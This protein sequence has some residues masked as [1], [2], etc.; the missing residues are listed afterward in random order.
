MENQIDIKLQKEE[1]QF[2]LSEDEHNARLGY[3]T[4]T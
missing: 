1:E 2:I 4:Y 3:S